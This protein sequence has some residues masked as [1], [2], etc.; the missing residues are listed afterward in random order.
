MYS[1]IAYPACGSSHLH[2]PSSDILSITRPVI[3][4]D[5]FTLVLMCLHSF[6]RVRSLFMLVLNG[7]HCL[8]LICVG[9]HLYRFVLWI[10]HGPQLEGSIKG[11]VLVTL[12][13]KV[14]YSF[15]SFFYIL[16]A[17]HLSIEW[18]GLEGSM[19]SCPSARLLSPSQHA[20]DCHFQASC[21][22]ACLVISIPTRI[23]SQRAP[24]I[25]FHSQAASCAA[26]FMQ[27][28]L[29]ANFYCSTYSR[30]PA[31]ILDAFALVFTRFRC[32]FTHS[33]L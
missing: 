12:R 24:S 19:L 33:Q 9:S 22:S 18:S 3:A 6:Q 2:L 7:T 1:C 31:L 29:P 26:I 11:P 4:S 21:P 14:C 28:E 23:L 17:K 27:A 25:H 8:L 20:F 10:S 30:P 32:S 13:L 15:L 16:I 5:T